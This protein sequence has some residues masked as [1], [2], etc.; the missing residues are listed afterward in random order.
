MTV[1][2]PALAGVS[3]DWEVRLQL[4]SAKLHTA[5]NKSLQGKLEMLLIR[6]YCSRNLLSFVSC[7]CHKF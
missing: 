1:G 4:P 7:Q 5:V 6:S 3:L 2:I